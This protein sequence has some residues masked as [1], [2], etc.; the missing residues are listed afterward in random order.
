MSEKFSKRKKIIIWMIICIFYSFLSTL[1]D[2]PHTSWLSEVQK[3]L[4]SHT[5]TYVIRNIYAYIISNLKETS[6]DEF[7]F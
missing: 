3:T 2:I 4:Y 5:E 7:F 1:I 6:S